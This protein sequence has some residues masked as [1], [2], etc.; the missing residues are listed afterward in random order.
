M[1]DWSTL[2][3]VREDA[4]PQEP[5]RGPAEYGALDL[6]DVTFDLSRAPFQGEAGGDGGEVLA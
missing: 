6:V 5:E 4:D 2:T 3:R 1:T